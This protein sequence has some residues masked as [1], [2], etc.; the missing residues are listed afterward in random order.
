MNSDALQENEES[1]KREMP[2]FTR[3]FYGEEREI[4]EM[5]GDEKPCLFPKQ[6]RN[7]NIFGRESSTR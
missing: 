3:P 4:I 6:E 1:K 2:R 7:L 5:K